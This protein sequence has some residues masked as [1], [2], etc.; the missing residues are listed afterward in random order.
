MSLESKKHTVD[1]NAWVEQAKHDPSRYFERQATEILLAAIGA[2]ES[3]AAKLFLK[4]GIL[5]G[6]VYKSPRHTADI[7]FTADFDPSDY[8]LE[9]LSES[10]DEEM[11][12]AAAQ[13]GYPDIVCQ[14]QTVKKRP[15]ADSFDQYPFPAIELKIAYAR[16]GSS[17]HKRF[18]DKQCPTTLKVEISFNE[19][20]EA[21]EWVNLGESAGIQAY[22]FAELM[23]EKIR[24]LLQQPIRKRNRRQDVYDIAYLVRGGVLSDQE[25]LEVLK[26]LIKKSESRDF[27]PSLESISDPEVRRRAEKEWTSMELEVDDLPPF[28][29]EF[30]IVEDFYES[31]PWQK[32]K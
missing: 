2:S 30:K 1:V 10:F 8:M 9:K 27:T 12:R 31:L 24:A 15:K 23:A 13:L 32:L 19:P 6:V 28:D 3:F 25:K 16:R 20:V 4:G 11:K 22:A 17:S 29:E 18:A 5:M 7:D 26:R 21:V 14:V